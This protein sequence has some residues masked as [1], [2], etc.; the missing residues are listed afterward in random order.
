MSSLHVAFRA[1]PEK[2]DHVAWCHYK[3]Q[4]WTLAG[5]LAAFSTALL[6][7]RFSIPPAQFPHAWLLAETFSA[8]GCYYE[9]PVLA[10]VSQLRAY[11]SGKEGAI[12][13]AGSHTQER[14]CSLPHIPLFLP[15]VFSRL[16][17]L[18]PGLSSTSLSPEQ[19]SP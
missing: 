14:V 17:F 4:P 9:W 12:F 16:R 5:S 15:T 6:G 3:A 11:L 2:T 13:P 10:P 18:L 1:A 7:S 19:E 8:A